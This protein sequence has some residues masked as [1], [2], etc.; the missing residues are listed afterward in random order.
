MKKILL[1]YGALV[2]VVV[3]LAFAKFN[4]FNFLSSFGGKTAVINNHS[5]K[6][7]IANDDKTRQIGLSKR[8]SL[9]K[10]TG[11]LFIFPKKGIYSFWMKDTEI[12]LDMLFIDGNKIT[13]IVKNAPA[14]AGNNGQLPIY[15]PPSEVNYV[16]ELN[17]GESDKNKFKTGD[18]VTLKGVK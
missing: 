1:A 10:N 17:G 9:D 5:Y 6:L 8:K 16:L 2:V 3:L 18:T 14:Q 15:T 13:Y 11:M 12:P 4:G 7:L